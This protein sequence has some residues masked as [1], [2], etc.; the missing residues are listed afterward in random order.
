MS[1]WLSLVGLLCLVS[2][3]S[4]GQLIDRKG[5]LS[6]HKKPDPGSKIIELKQW[7]P[8]QLSVV[9]TNGNYFLWRDSS[10]QPPEQAVLDGVRLAPGYRFQLGHSDRGAWR[11]DTLEVVSISSNSITL[12]APGTMQQT[13]LPLVVFDAGTPFPDELMVTPVNESYCLYRNPA[14]QTRQQ[15]MDEAI[16]VKPGT[17]F[18]LEYPANFKNV[19]FAILAVSSTNAT[20]QCVSPFS[21]RTARVPLVVNRR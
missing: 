21:P 16:A 1:R 14:Q 15:A 5:P 9:A 8:S 20:L 13:R 18:T 4:R 17:R 2:S 10:N 12:K 19:T 7:F 11:N 6:I 3:P